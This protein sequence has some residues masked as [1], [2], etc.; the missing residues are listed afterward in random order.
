MSVAFRAT[1]LT[2]SA[3]FLS[4]LTRRGRPRRNRSDDAF[5]NKKKKKGKGEKQ[6]FPGF[7][8]LRLLQRANVEAAQD[9]WSRK[10]ESMVRVP[11]AQI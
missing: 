7:S 2:K 5:V 10:R 4:G 6:E 9:D 1:A 8:S 3:C 11:I